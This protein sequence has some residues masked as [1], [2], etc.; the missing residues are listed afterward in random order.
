MLRPDPGVNRKRL[1]FCVAGGRYPMAECGLI[2]LSACAIARR[3]SCFLQ[4]VEDFAV[5]RLIAEFCCNIPASRHATVPDLP[6]AINT[7]I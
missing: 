6:S 2:V 7:S 4:A 5:E 1:I 3:R